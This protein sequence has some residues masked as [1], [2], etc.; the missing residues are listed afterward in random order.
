MNKKLGY[1]VRSMASATFG[2][3]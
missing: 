2:F 1:R 3:R